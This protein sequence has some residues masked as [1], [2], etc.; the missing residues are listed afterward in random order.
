MTEV[1]KTLTNWRGIEFRN[2]SIVKFK[3]QPDEHT[4]HVYDITIE[5]E[6]NRTGNWKIA[7]GP[8]GEGGHYVW[9]ADLNYIEKIIEF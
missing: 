2:G 8:T 6:N 5:L 3:N 9:G 1:N 7:G 4:V